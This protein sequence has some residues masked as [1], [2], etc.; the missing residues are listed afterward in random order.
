VRGDERNATARSV[1]PE[2][3]PAVSFCSPDLLPC[4]CAS[5]GRGPHVS[6]G[7]FLWLLTGPFSGP[8]RVLWAERLLRAGPVRFRKWFFVFIY[9]T[10][11]MLDSKIH[12]S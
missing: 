1:S 6:A 12:I 2:K 9:F 5:D 3:P 8:S 11:L 4:L 10:D 7:L